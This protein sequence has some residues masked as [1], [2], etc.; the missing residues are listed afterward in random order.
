MYST[1]ICDVSLHA[2]ISTG[3]RMHDV[4]NRRSPHRSKSTKGKRDPRGMQ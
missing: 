3:N 2:T 1:K 4:M